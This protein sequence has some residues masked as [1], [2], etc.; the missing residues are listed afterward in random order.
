MHIH[1]D[2]DSFDADTL[3]AR[4]LARTQTGP[5]TPEALFKDLP[6]VSLGT[7]DTEHALP[8]GSRVFDAGTQLQAYAPSGEPIARILENYDAD[9]E[10]GF[11]AL[12]GSQVQINTG[13]STVDPDT[14]EF[15]LR[16]GQ[17]RFYCADGFEHTYDEL[18]FREFE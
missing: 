6:G 5:M 3:L 11:T 15:R 17:L 8:A 12:P 16:A 10:V 4:L 9:T 7:K 13:E 1:I 18:T 2:P 14:A